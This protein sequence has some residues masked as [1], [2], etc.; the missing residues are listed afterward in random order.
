MCVEPRPCRVLLGTRP[1]NDVRTSDF[2]SIRY[3][4][5]DDNS[6]IYAPHFTFALVLCANDSLLYGD[7]PVALRPWRDS[8][9][10]TPD[11]ELL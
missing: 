9:T 10:N 8:L 6:D 1:V 3:H 4:L 5:Q 2:P 11:Y 7:G